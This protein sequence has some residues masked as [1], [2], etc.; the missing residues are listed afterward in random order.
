MQAQQVLELIESIGSLHLSE[1]VQG[2]LR[3]PLVIRLPER[4]RASPE[5]IGAMHLRTADGERL[6][7]S[8]LADIDIVESPSTIR[9][10][11]GQRCLNITCN[12]RGRDLGSFVAEV[13]KKIAADVTLPAGRY[14]IEYGGQFENLIRAERRLMI[15]VPIALGA[16]L[17][18]AV[19]HLP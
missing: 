1:V 2:Q 17:H 14:R 3:F 12:V 11:W 19:F 13:Q 15:V 7:L 9:R 5:A 16:D 4:H 18:A 6:P 8:R 10:E